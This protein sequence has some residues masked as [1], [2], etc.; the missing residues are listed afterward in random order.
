MRDHELSDIL[1]LGWWPGRYFCTVP[2][3]KLE[4]GVNINPSSE[5]KRDS[6]NRGSHDHRDSD[7][8]VYDS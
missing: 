8:S 3:G 5:R 7:K 4:G 1:L 2:R 6:R